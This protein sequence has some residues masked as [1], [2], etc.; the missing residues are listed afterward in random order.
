MAGRHARLYSVL[1]R[2]D[3]LADPGRHN[4]VTR[5][6]NQ[7]EANQPVVDQRHVAG[8]GEGPGVAGSQQVGV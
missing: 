4:I 3:G 2:F 6:Q 1:Q 5:G 8:C 7:H